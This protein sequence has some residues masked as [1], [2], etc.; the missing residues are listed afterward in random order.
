MLSSG[1]GVKGKYF[2]SFGFQE[3]FWPEEGA[4][5]KEKTGRGVIF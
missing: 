2:K 4:V 1:T 5:N 3:L